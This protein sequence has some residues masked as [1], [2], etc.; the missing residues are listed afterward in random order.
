[1][2]LR[3]HWSPILNINVIQIKEVNVCLITTN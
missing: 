3:T 2:G 1:M